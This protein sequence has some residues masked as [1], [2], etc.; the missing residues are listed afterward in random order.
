MS[1]DLLQ[2]MRKFNRLLQRVGSDRVVFTDICQVLSDVVE[3][4]IAVVSSNAKILGVFNKDEEAFVAGTQHIDTM[5]NDQLLSIMEVKENMPMSSIFTDDPISKKY[6]ACII[7]IVAGGQRLGTL[8]V[9]KK[10]GS[11]VTDDI[12]LGE[13]GATIIA[14]EV[15]R[16]LRV[17]IEDEERKV[18]VVKSAIGTLSYSELEAIFHIFDKLD[19]TEGLLIASKIADKVGIT[20][21]VIVNALRKFES[22]GVIESRSLG[23]KGTYIK[24]LN[25]A[26]IEELDK[27]R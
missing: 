17:E 9:Y 25:D 23:M 18:A 26:L 11:Y 4:N 27:L 20:R 5:I 13:Y 2:K 1:V 7:P 16:S 8:L 10:E 6:N 15:L 24:V 22:A 14:V 3:S 12:I 19:G 21:S